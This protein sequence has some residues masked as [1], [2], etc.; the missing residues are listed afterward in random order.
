MLLTA[1]KCGLEKILGQKI[2]GSEK[3]IWPNS[4]L[5]LYDLSVLCYCFVFVPS[6]LTADLNNNNTEF[7]VGG[8]V[9]HTYT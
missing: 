2:F 9:T 1:T 6:V 8:W 5:V 4:T 7:D 3:I